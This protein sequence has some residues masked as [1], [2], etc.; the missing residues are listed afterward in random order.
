MVRSLTV[1]LFVAAVLG[2][3][4]LLLRP[5]PGDAARSR[6]F[7]LAVEGDVMSPEEMSVGEGDRVKLRVTADAPLELHLHGYD[8]EREVDPD[9]PAEIS[10][11]AAMTGRFEMESEETG[12]GLAVLTV[13]PR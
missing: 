3:L 2:G 13:R 6:S 7:D 8:I 1:I 12:E 5:D 11:K 9:E 10:F 4:F